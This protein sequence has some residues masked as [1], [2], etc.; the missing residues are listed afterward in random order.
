VQHLAIFDYVCVSAS[1]EDRVVEY[2][3]HLHDHFVD[4]VVVR[5]GRYTVPTAP[6]YSI[7]MRPESLA[8]YAYPDGPVWKGG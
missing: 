2:V 1:L 7:T 6:G 3:D 4:P 8:M 5:D